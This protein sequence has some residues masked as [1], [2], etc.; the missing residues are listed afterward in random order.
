MPFPPKGSI[1]ERVAREQAIHFGA[2]DEPHLHCNRRSP[3]SPNGHAKLEERLMAVS[4]MRSPLHDLL[5]LVSFPVG[6]P[7][8]AADKPMM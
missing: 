3:G 5:V 4:G 1:G 6:L 2:P 8:F 7:R